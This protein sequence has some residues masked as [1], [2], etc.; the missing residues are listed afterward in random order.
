MQ[1]PQHCYAMRSET[2]C[3]SLEEWDEDYKG[4]L[5]QQSWSRH[6]PACRITLTMK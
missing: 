4:G 1:N 2:A 3:A 6:W 5:Q